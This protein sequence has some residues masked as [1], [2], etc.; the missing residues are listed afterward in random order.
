LLARKAGICFLSFLK[1]LL[2]FIH[3]NYLSTNNHYCR[4]KMLKSLRKVYLKAIPIVSGHAVYRNLAIR[5][6][7]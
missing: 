3:W 5:G 1:C 6:L 4:R 2:Y 7:P